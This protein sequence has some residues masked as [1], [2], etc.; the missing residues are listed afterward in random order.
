MIAQKDLDLRGP[1]EFLGTRQ[2]GRIA[3]EAYGVTDLMLIEETR[4]CADRLL[5]D[6]SLEADKEHLTALA[7]VTY[8]KALDSAAMN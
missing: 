3:P 5:K 2:H 7:F 8:K 1:G 4:E 6:K